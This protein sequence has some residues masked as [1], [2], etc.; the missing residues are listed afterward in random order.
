M[1][2]DHERDHLPPCLLRWEPGL[3]THRLTR[4]PP[5]SLGRHDTHHFLLHMLTPALMC[6]GMGLAYI[7]AFHAPHVHGLKVAVVGTSSSQQVLAQ[8]IKDRGGDAVDVTT[9]PNRAE[10]E[11]RILDRDLVGAYVPKAKTPELLVA[12]AN[13]DSSATVAEALFK[14]VADKQQTPLRVT[15]LTRLSSGDVTGQGLFFLLVALSIGSNG[16]AVALSAFSATFRMWTRVALGIGASLLVSVIG[17]VLAGPVFNVIDH[18]RIAVWAMA[19][20]YSA[21]ILTVGLALQFFLKRWGTLAMMVLFVMVNFTSSGG[22]LQPALQR[23]FFGALHSFWNGAGF[24]E[25]ARSLLY[26]DSAGFGE[27]IWSLVIW[28]AAGLVLAAAAAAAERRVVAA[29]GVPAHGNRGV[30][31]SGTPVH[32]AQHLTGAAGGAVAPAHSPA[33]TPR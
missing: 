12:K 27:R 6:L 7:G 18:D 23:G 22:I 8:T 9:V 31:S 33:V 32:P 25:G 19:W 20:L 10:A 3:S 11:R 21:G 13:S 26:F 16:F 30:T 24:V 4:R 1:P 17:I 5:T 15:D 2:S 29:P 28:L 14:V